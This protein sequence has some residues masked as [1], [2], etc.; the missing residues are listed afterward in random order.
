MFVGS[1]E[2]L[3]VAAGRLPKEVLPITSSPFNLFSP[4]VHVLRIKKGGA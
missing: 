2:H 1:D 4:M 3:R